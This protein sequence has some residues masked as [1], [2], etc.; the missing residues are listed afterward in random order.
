M[1]IEV[2]DRIGMGRCEVRTKWCRARAC[3][4]IGT[5]LT[6]ES[7]RLQVCGACLSHMADTGKWFIPGTRPE[8]ALIR[9]QRDCDV[10]YTPNPDAVI[11]EPVPVLSRGR[12]EVQTELCEAQAWGVLTAVSMP[13]CRNIRLCGACLEKKAVSGVWDLGWSGGAAVA[14]IKRLTLLEAAP[15]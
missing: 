5:V 3:G 9:R 4:A 2:T 8:P 10:T 7:A 1:R 14:E 12:C 6:P 13:D 11:V 15:A